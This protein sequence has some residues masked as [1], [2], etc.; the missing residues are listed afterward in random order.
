MSFYSVGIKTNEQGYGK[1]LLLVQCD[2]WFGSSPNLVNHLCAGILAENI[3]RYLYFLSLKH[4]KI[5]YFLSLKHTKILYF[6][7]LKHTKILYFLSL[8][9]TKIL[10]FLSLMALICHNF[11]KTL[12]LGEKNLFI[13]HVWEFTSYIITMPA[14]YVLLQWDAAIANILTNG[15]AAFKW[16]LLSHWLK[17]CDSINCCGNTEPWLLCHHVISSWSIESM[18]VKEVLVSHG[19]IFQ[20]PVTSYFCEIIQN[21]NIFFSH[22]KV[23]LWKC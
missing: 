17:A 16:K 23:I 2:G 12:L 21:P 7:S 19:E 6:L 20:L 11:F 9:N 22:E 14:D 5:L 3:Q 8:K 13:I 4:T 15:R 18:K 1:N 10:Y